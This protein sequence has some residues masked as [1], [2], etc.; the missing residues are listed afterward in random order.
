MT[1]ISSKDIQ[2]VEEY[3]PFFD[4]YGSMPGE[5]TV[6]SVSFQGKIYDVAYV[7]S[8]VDGYDEEEDNAC[9]RLDGGDLIYTLVEAIGEMTPQEAIEARNCGRTATFVEEAEALIN[10][11]CASV[12][13]ADGGLVIGY[14]A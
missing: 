14:S 9:F 4:E 11:A 6:I 2:I 3:E 8:A 5:R 10:G 12:I 13:E 1:K 7:H